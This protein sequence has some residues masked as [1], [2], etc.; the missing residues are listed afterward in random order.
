VTTWGTSYEGIISDW[1]KILCHAFPRLEPDGFILGGGGKRKMRKKLAIMVIILTAI[2]ISSFDCTQAADVKIGIIDTQEVLKESKAAKKARNLLMDELNEKRSV[3]AKKQDEVRLLE[4]EIKIK[5]EGMTE[6]QRRE[7]NDQLGREVKN[8]QRLKTDLE[9]ELNKKNV[10]LTQKILQEVSDVVKEF[11]KK[12][13]YT[14][15]LEKKSVVS[16]DEAI[17]ITDKIIRLYD[18][19]KK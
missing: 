7:K 12:E 13:K 11:M 6:S 8:L 14:L 5:G 18:A 17:D 16:S 1:S 10:D 3:F 9:E 19:K 4:E 2:A 15:I